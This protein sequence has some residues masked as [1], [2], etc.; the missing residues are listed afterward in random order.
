MGKGWDREPSRA[1]FDP[2]RRTMLRFPRAIRTPPDASSIRSASARTKG[3][4][5]AT[6][7]PRSIRAAVDASIGMPSS[8][9]VTS[10]AASNALTLSRARA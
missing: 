9:T 7:C 6:T 3:S 5:G 10:V 8:N 1:T 4:S 2:I